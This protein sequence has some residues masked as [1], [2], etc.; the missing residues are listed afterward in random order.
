MSDPHD[1][2]E[3]PDDSPGAED[4]YEAARRDNLKK[5]ADL[6]VD[7]WGRRFDDRQWIGD[8]RGLSD[9]IRYRLEDGEETPLPDLSSE[10]PVNMRQWKAEQG[11]GEVVGPTVRTAGRIKLL[12]DTGKLL[13]IDIED[14]TGS[15]QLFIGKKQV[16]EENFALA[17]LFRSRRPHRSGRLVGTHQHGRIDDLRRTPAFSLQVDPSSAWQARR[18]G[19]YRTPSTEAVCGPGL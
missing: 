11:K 4:Q 7:P 9:Q 8:I 17:Q 6:G 13:F 1:A 14:W 12:R 10:P 15:I 3:I 16:G 19:R 18:P 5:I 2:A